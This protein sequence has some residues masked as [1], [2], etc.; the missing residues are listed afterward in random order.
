MCCSTCFRCSCGHCIRS[1]VRI[2]PQSTQ[3]QCICVWLVFQCCGEYVYSS[4][5]T[6][7][8]SKDS[9]RDDCKQHYQAKQ[10]VRLQPTK[11]VREPRICR[12]D[13][14]KAFQ[15]ETM[16]PIVSCVIP[17]IEVKSWMLSQ[18]FLVLEMASTHPLVRSCQ[19]VDSKTLS[20]PT[21][22][23]YRDS[24]SFRSH[25]STCHRE[26]EI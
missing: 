6:R 14:N 26:N 20:S 4:D 11:H 7:T 9:H 21:T 19:V 12:V 17:C 15:K 16:R 22:Q 13:L 8:V 23:S 2:V 25:S 5:S 3:L 10:H 1:L 24:A 18:Y